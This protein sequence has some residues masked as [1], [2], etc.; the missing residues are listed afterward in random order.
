MNSPKS[1]CCERSRLNG[2]V[3]ARQ[4]QTRHIV[5]VSGLT[6]RRWRKRS[7]VRFLFKDARSTYDNC[8]GD[9][10]DPLMVSEQYGGGP[11]Q[12]QSLAV[13]WLSVPLKLRKNP[14]FVFR[15]EKIN[16]RFST[17]ERIFSTTTSKS[18]FKVPLNNH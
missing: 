7:P 18:C 13:T 16:F 9:V 11:T 15:L 4:P 2:R 6:I 17:Q 3:K 10:K 8:V 12:S 14:P 5:M 1:D